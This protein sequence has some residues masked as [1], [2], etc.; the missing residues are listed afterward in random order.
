MPRR[1]PTQPTRRYNAP[2]Q[3]T[4]RTVR[5]DIASANMYSEPCNH[6][7][8]S[9]IRPLVIFALSTTQTA[10]DIAKHTREEKER[11]VHLP[12]FHVAPELYKGPLLPRNLS[13]PPHNSPPL[14]CTRA[15][16]IEHR[17]HQGT[18]QYKRPQ[19]VDTYRAFNIR[20]A[21]YWI[22][23][24]LLLHLLRGHTTIPLAKRSSM[25]ATESTPVG[26]RKI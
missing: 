4:G 20:A 17:Q 7:A 22:R 21:A 8:H 12:P 5:V 15:S 14:T 16:Q 2:S 10:V 19:L 3:P 13:P 9:G 25:L 6:P 23:A 26:S 18:P 11:I 1:L 24:V